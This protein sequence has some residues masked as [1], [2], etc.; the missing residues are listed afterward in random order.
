MKTITCFGQ[1]WAPK[2][3]QETLSHEDAILHWNTAA[4]ID[5]EVTEQKDILRA[6]HPMAEIDEDVI[7]QQ[8]YADDVLETWESRQ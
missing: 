4:M 6:N 1:E 7:L 3:R 2:T 5:S 8:I